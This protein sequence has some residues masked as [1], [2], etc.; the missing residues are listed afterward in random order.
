MC[1]IYKFNNNRVWPLIGSHP[2][3]LIINILIFGILFAFLPFIIIYLS[4][5]INIYLSH[6]QQYSIK[7]GVIVFPSSSNNWIQWAN[8]VNN[9]I[10]IYTRQITMNWLS[11]RELRINEL[12][13]HMHNI[14]NL[15]WAQLANDKKLS[16]ANNT[17]TIYSGWQCLIPTNNSS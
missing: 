10:S 12:R 9:F 13:E 16:C 1:F 5:L 2:C 3:L 8:A 15:T 7:F 6:R 17:N 4:M 14:T 11:N